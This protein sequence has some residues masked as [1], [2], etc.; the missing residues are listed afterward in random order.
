MARGQKRVA[1]SPVN[2]AVPADIAAE[3]R[4]AKLDTLPLASRAKYMKEYEAYKAW[5][6]S[7]GT[8]FISEDSLLVYVRTLSQDGYVASTIRAALSMI[9]ACIK[10]YDGV[11]IGAYVNVNSYMRNASGKH[12][13]KKARVLTSQQLHTFCNFAPDDEYFLIKVILIVGVIGCCRKSELVYLMMKYVTVTASSILIDIPPEVTKTFTANTFSIVGPFYTIV[14]RYLESR[15]NIANERFFLVYR[16]GSFIDCACGDKTIG[17]VPKVVAKFL[18][19]PEPERYTSHSI[20]RSSA[21]V[22]AE[23]GCTDTELRLHGRWKSNSCASGYLEDTDIRRHKVSAQIT[24]AIL[25]EYHLSNEP[26]TISYNHEN[27]YPKLAKKTLPVSTRQQSNSVT[28]ALSVP[29]RKQSKGSTSTVT[30]SMLG[31]LPV[32]SKKRSS[33]S[34]PSMSNATSVLQESTVSTVVDAAS[35]WS[36]EPLLGTIQQPPPVSTAYKATPIRGLSYTTQHKASSV[37]SH[38]TSQPA[39]DVE[40]ED[41][42]D[43]FQSD[44]DDEPWSNAKSDNVPVS[45]STPKILSNVLLQPATTVGDVSHSII[46]NSVSTNVQSG[47]KSVSRVLHSQSSSL[48]NEVSSDIFEDMLLATSDDES[49]YSNHDIDNHNEAFGLSRDGLSNAASHPCD[50]QQVLE[51][52]SDQLWGGASSSDVPEPLHFELQETDEGKVVFKRLRLSSTVPSHEPLVIQ[53]LRVLSPPSSEEP[54][55]PPYFEQLEAVEGNFE[56]PQIAQDKVVQSPMVEVT[57][58]EQ[59]EVV[60]GNFE[61]PQIAQGNFSTH[62]EVLQSS[63]VE[64]TNLTDVPGQLPSMKPDA[65]LMMLL[66]EQLI[67]GQH[68]FCHSRV[69]LLHLIVMQRRSTIESKD[70][71]DSR[72]SLQYNNTPALGPSFPFDA[73]REPPGEE[74][75]T[76]SI[77]QRDRAKL[78]YNPS[79]AAGM[80]VPQVKH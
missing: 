44:F 20:R 78:R 27:Q 8:P 32:P 68:L 24:N 50:G 15:K 71:G 59:L 33:T 74:R 14:R 61:Q 62:D 46:H 42:S 66:H 13:P 77:E 69:P 19:L 22:Y 40:N 37:L 12:K 80:H 58:L 17:S 43:L 25:P 23:S 2:H 60:R 56:Q 26:I 79:A 31:N 49:T 72:M 75:R 52:E 6:V 30:S 9:K 48:I 11:D 45:K 10:A 55:S 5:C 7:R 28:K 67:P 54:P 47:Q 36:F 65:L 3:A 73:R 53:G 21:T 57:N 4:E 38:P 51:P 1:V 16:S 64:V 39:F 63:M 18:G 41:F 76:R 35:S 34:M 70:S 29:P